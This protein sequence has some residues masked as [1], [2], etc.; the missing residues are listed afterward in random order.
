[1]TRKLIKVCEDTYDDI[2]NICGTAADI[3]EYFMELEACLRVDNSIPDDAVIHFEVR[4]HYSGADLYAS[5]TRLE[6]DEE[7]EKRIKSEKAKAKR[8]M[9][10]EAK[11]RAEYERLKAKF[12]G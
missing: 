5:Y 3:A 11:E 12:E 8:A 10:K 6:N 4:Q 1:M 9:D 2:G 7:Y